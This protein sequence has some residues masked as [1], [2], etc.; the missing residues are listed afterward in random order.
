MVE[1]GDTTFPGMQGKTVL[2][3]AWLTVL[4]VIHVNEKSICNYLSLEPTS[5]YM[6][7]QNTFCKVLIYNAFLWNAAAKYMTV[8][9]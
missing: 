1:A 7:T 2:H 8:I 6:Q 3:L 5:L 9:I 4:P